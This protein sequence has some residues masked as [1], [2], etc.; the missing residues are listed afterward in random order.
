MI[1]VWHIC[2]SSHIQASGIGMTEPSL[3]GKD[4]TVAQAKDLTA[5]QAK[6]LASHCKGW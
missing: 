1:E 6:E 3:L 5:A 4:L 2:K